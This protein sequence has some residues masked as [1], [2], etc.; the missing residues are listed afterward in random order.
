MT[1]REYRDLER[2]IRS[3]AQRIAAKGEPLSA[4]EAARRLY[5]IANEI[6]GIRQAHET[7]IDASMGKRSGW[8]V[9]I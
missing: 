6:T 7:G 9:D 8:K 5:E 4:Q 2:A 3:E 1:L